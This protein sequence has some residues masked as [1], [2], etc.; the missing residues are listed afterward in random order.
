MKFGEGAYAW[1][2]HRGY[3]QEELA[4]RCDLSNETIS[5]YEIRPGDK[6]DPGEPSPKTR[7]KWAKGLGITPEQFYT[8]PREVPEQVK[9]LDELIDEIRSGF[10]SG[11]YTKNEIERELL[12]FML[13]IKNA[14]RNTD[15]KGSRT[16]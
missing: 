3:T 10:G 8:L 15:S 16:P 11:R 14:E 9:N 2:V 4:A 13:E 12:E 7:S 5:R 6:S 1:R